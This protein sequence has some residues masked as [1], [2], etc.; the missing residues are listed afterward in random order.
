[1]TMFIQVDNS[2]R[3]TCE[4]IWAIGDCI[5]APLLAHAASREAVEAVNSIIDKESQ[6]LDPLLV[7]SCTYCQPQVASIGISE[8]A[9][10][11]LGYETITGKFPFR[12][13][14]K[15]VAIGEQEGFVKV[16]VD[17]GVVFYTRQVDT[18]GTTT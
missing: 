1:M 13:L 14:G 11:E 5:G 2:Y 15:A 3:T 9:A 7:P 4:N 17:K 16:V 12:P 6:Y 8:A 18:I 10:I